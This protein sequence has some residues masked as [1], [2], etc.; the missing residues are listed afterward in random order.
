MRGVSGSLSFIAFGVGVAGMV[1]PALAAECKPLVVQVAAPMT[2][3]RGVPAIPVEIGG[4][5]KRLVVDTASPFSTMSQ[6]AIKE[7]NLNTLKARTRIVNAAGL[8]SDRYV[9]LPS[10]KI[11]ASKTDNVRFMA[12]SE[13]GP[14][15]RTD[16]SVAG[17]LGTDIIK[18]FDVDM[19]FGAHTL[20]L[21]S[22]DHCEG[23]EL[24][25][26]A[27]AV[28]IVPM[29]FGA[30]GKPVIAAT[31]DGKTLEAVIDT[32]SA[33]TSVNLD[34]AEDRFNL[35]PDDPDMQPVGQLGANPAAKVYR[36]KFKTLTFEGVTVT[37]PTIVLLPDEVKARLQNNGPRAGSL[38]RGEEETQRLPDMILG[39]SILSKLH[40]YI[41][42]KERKVTITQ[43]TPP[44]GPAPSG[45]VP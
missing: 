1:S 35:K 43:A 7:M 27:P 23:K 25:W 11:G 18:N 26:A 4:V 28:A 14:M 40:V 19:D 2:P 42:Y 34:I 41:A 30:G 12:G 45:G 24:Y 6:P 20:N 33:N 15:D 39:M 9:I 44:D 29:R 13:P 10:L 38:I 36:R 5:P 3:S 21:I 22:Q 8:S 16:S 32:G 31:L 37:D 17:R